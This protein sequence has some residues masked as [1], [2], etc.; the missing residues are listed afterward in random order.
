MIKRKEKAK[1]G[2]RKVGD[3]GI[4]KDD[5]NAPGDPT[6]GVLDE[7]LSRI[8]AIEWNPNEG[9]GSWAAVALGSGLVKIMD[10]GLDRKSTSNEA[11]QV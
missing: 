10:L 4:E 3:D 1:A 2:L 6:K 5:A 8:T 7:P 11:N 9:W